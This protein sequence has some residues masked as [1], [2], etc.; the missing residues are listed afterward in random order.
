MSARSPYTRRPPSRPPPRKGPHRAFPRPPLAGRVPAPLWSPPPNSMAQTPGGTTVPD[1]KSR[2]VERCKHWAA[3][4][5]CLRT[6]AEVSCALHVRPSHNRLPPRD[7]QGLFPTPFRPLPGYNHDAA[8]APLPP[9]PP[10]PA[11]W[12]IPFLSPSPSA[13]GGCAGTAAAVRPAGVAHTPSTTCS[14]DPGRGNVAQRE[15]RGTE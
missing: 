5:S 8:A 9:L 2:C 1:P 6:L 15:G 14:N 3:P 11:K 12:R 4:Q 10:N 13:G 7:T